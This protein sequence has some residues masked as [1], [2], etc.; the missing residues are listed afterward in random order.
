LGTRLAAVRIRLDTTAHR[1]LDITSELVVADEIPDSDLPAE[2]PGLLATVEAAGSRRVCRLPQAITPAGTPGINC[3]VSELLCRALAEAT[4]AQVV[5]HG[6]LGHDGL[7]AGEVSERHLFALI[8]YENSIMTADLTPA[9]IETAVAEQLAN[10]ASYVYCGVWGAEM[11]CSVGSASTAPT[12]HLQRLADA[13]GP[14][15]ERLRVA[16]NSYTAAGGGGRFPRLFEILRTPQSHL[17]HTGVEARTAVRDYL[18]RHANEPLVVRPWIS[19]R[20]PSAPKAA[21]AEGP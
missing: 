16:V 11:S 20:L 9:Q 14:L 10:R 13:K 21:P 15:P 12:V 3:A 17:R 19:G 5:L 1:V 2:V 8:P 6:T 7:P 4:G 18:G